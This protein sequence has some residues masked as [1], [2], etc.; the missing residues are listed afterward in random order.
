MALPPHPNPVLAVTLPI[1][2]S[3]PPGTHAPTEAFRL[4]LLGVGAVHLACLMLRARVQGSVTG[5]SWN[6]NFNFAETAALPAPPPP[7]IDFALGAAF[8]VDD[9]NVLSGQA[10]RA[11]ALGASTM[12][13]MEVMLANGGAEDA[14]GLLALSAMMR[15]Q[16]TKYLALA[17]QNPDEIRSDAA[18]GA[19]MAV[20]LIDVSTSP[21][22]P[23]RTSNSSL[24]CI[25]P[26]L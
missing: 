16:A 25:P 2:L 19:T 24:R 11:P 14:R 5:P 18:L 9:L 8:D 4:A 23:L 6:N 17:C 10:P 26:W 21:S 13:A 12:N 22:L 20:V 1:V 3:Q 7:D 15:L